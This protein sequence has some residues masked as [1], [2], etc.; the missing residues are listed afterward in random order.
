MKRLHA[1]VYTARL[2]EL[3]RQI[4]P[5][6]KEN[7]RVLDVGCGF[8]ALGKAILEAPASPPGVK[9]FGLER[10]KRGNE[11]IPVEGYD[12]VIIPYAA[13]SFDVV[14]LADVLH[15]EHDPHC[16][17]REC[18]RVARRLLVIKDHKVEGLLAQQR[19]ALLDWAANAPYSVPCLYRY[20]T[21]G[22]WHDWFSKHDLTIV[23]EARS[24][25]LYP[26][27]YNTIFGGKLQYLAILGPRKEK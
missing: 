22:E 5:H 27:I 20:N 15:H 25:H 4:T 21:S 3:V 14:I 11:L 13:D 6:L 17:L 7:D 9:L 1:P 24:L 10:V 12:G 18:I 23:R 8:G 19:I 26:P 2:E 16:L